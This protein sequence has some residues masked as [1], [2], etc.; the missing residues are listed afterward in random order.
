M[1][2]NFHRALEFVFKWEGG[3]VASDPGGETKY[4]ISKKSFPDIEITALTKD[5]AESLYKKYYWDRIGGDTLPFPYDIIAFDTAVNQGPGRATKWLGE[6][7][8]GRHYILLRLAHYAKLNDFDKYGRGWVNRLIDL[9][10][11]IE[12]MK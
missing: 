12:E 11:L 4:G 2:K 7:K 8:T 10:K 3:Y 5:N 6:A 1:E 9:S